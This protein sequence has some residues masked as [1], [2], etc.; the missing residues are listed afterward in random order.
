[1]SWWGTIVGGAFGFLLGGPIGA[2]LGVY[3]G[4]NFDAGL[5]Q[6]FGTTNAFDPGAQQ[7]VQAT[8]FTATFS[9]MG[10]IAKADGR[11]SK[12]EILLANRI[13]D[14]MRLTVAM[15]N[16][17]RDLF[18]K[19]KQNGFQ[20]EAVL[21]QFKQEMHGRKTLSQMFLEIQIR[22]ASA[23]GK[24]R[25]DEKNILNKVANALGFSHYELESLI[26]RHN[27]EQRFENSNY[28]SDVD[29]ISQA[30][31]VLGLSSSCSDKELKR[32]YRRLMSQHHPDKLVSKGLPD[33]MLTIAKE[34]TQEIK[35]AYE[36][37]KKERK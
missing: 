16:T 1:M 12:D 27:S 10:F 9:V 6:D 33:E 18:N 13:M 30:Y 11:I 20:F 25:K 14:E 24:L 26:S 23:D 7:R 17:A 37:I 4:R 8:F 19:G 15:K 22:A 2:L 36:V 34:K 31:G 29:R 32:T 35:A 21:A 3:A 28:T 5:A